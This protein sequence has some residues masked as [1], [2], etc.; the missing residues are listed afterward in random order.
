MYSNAASDAFTII[1]MIF[2]FIVIVSC[3]CADDGKPSKNRTNTVKRNTST[4]S[5]SSGRECPA[6]GAPHYHGYCEECGYQDINQ[7]WLGENG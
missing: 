4:Y 1:F 3:C 6:C 7:G 2:C 5:P